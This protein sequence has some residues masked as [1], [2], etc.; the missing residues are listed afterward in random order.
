MCELCIYIS[1][2]YSAIPVVRA[3]WLHLNPAEHH[4]AHPQPQPAS[5]TLKRK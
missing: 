2:T 1:Y 3:A 4:F 5:V